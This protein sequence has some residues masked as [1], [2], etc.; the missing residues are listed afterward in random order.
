MDETRGYCAKQ[1]KSTR[2]RS[3]SYDFTHV[4]NLRNKTEEHRGQDKIRQNKT[5]SER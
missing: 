3:L 4:W 5:K 2:E 1:N